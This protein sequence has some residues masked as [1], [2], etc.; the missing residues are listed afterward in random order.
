MAASRVR[1]HV[2]APSV[3][4]SCIVVTPALAYGSWSWFDDVIRHSPDVSWLVV[5]YGTVPAEAP[6]N[7]RFITL[8][9][10]DYL[11]VGRLGARTRFLWLNLLYVMPLVLLAMVHTWRLKPSVVV[12]NGIAA[13]SLLP[14]C[15]VASPRTRV[16]LAYHSAIGH[17]PDHVRGVIRTVLAPVSGA[18]CNSLGNERELRSVMPGR[19]VVSV[20]HWADDAFFTGDVR[21]SGS[22]RRGDLSVPIRVLY[23]GRTDPE[24]FGQC[25]RVCT[26]LAK[27]GLVELTVVGPTATVASPP[28]V[29]F[30][31][32]VSSRAA[33]HELYQHADVT[34][35]PADV[36][37]LS[38]P[39]VESLASGCP[40]IVSDIP[41]VGGKCDGSIRIPRSLVPKGVGVVVDG[42]DDREVVA[43]FRA[44]ATGAGTP[45]ER[46]VCRAFAS[47]R[48]SSRNIRLIIDAWFPG[49]ARKGPA[50]RR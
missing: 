35:A 4:H 46:Q 15:R 50:E 24:K 12:G 39:G 47:D 7:V 42:S 6:R 43:L 37:Y 9:G 2:E 34:W 1:N 14:F 30:I 25:L 5:G 45:G 31:G 8:R 20:E 3:W 32:Y 10:G 29:R 38:R 18:V 36:D 44:W 16:W 22:P 19:P 49:E 23:V 28:A 26:A 27:Q 21:P 41:A 13:A 33:L 17:L 40:I 48:F 11:K